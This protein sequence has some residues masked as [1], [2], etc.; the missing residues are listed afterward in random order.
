M[1]LT[2]VIVILWI[3]FGSCYLVHAFIFDGCVEKC[4]KHAADA[5][6]YNKICQ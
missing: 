4:V 3:V 2:K 1:S 5:I 6:C